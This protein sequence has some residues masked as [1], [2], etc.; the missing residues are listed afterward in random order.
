M[1][2]T[3]NEFHSAGLA[4]IKEQGFVG[5]STEQEAQTLVYFCQRTFPEVTYVYLNR[6]N[7]LYMVYND[8]GRSFL[9]EAVGRW[10]AKDLVNVEND[11]QILHHLGVPVPKTSPV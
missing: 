3:I 5:V 6:S 7:Y 4:K 9:G 11:Y 8:V 2:Q 10:L 1:S